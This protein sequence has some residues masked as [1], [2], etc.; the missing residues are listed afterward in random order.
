MGSKENFPNEM[1]YL[2]S[3]CQP[4]G[5]VLDETNN[6]EVLKQKKIGESN[7]QERDFFGGRKVTGEG[8]G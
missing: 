8:L 1:S 4:P 7:D 6:T 5:L 2:G 3:V